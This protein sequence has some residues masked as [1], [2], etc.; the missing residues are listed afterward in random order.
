MNEAIIIFVVILAVV[1]AAGFFFKNDDVKVAP[2]MM[3]AALAGGLIAGLGLTIREVVEGPMAYVDSIMTVMTA[4]I[5]MML[6]ADNGTFDFLLSKVCGKKR[7]AM[8][9]TILLILFIAIP[10]IFT[11]TMTASLV[12][13]GLIAGKFMLKN[14]ID[15]TKT[16]EFVV[17]SAFI[18]MLLPPVNLPVMISMVSRIG[19]YP[20]SYFGVALPLL[21]LGGVALVL[22][23]LT[24]SNR[25]I[26]TT[27]FKAE[28]A[29]GSMTC[30]IPIAVAVL[31]VFANDFLAGIVPFIGYP[32]IFTIAAILAVILPARK[33]NPLESCVKGVGSVAGVLAVF[34]GMG[35]I[36]EI[37]TLTGVGGYISTTLMPMGAGAVVAAALVMILVMIVLGFFFGG[38]SATV[39]G[40]LF[41]YAIATLAYGK[42]DTMMLIASG[43]AMGIAF[44]VATRG[45]TVNRFALSLDGTTDVNFKQV[46][47]GG[48]LP[49][50]AVLVIS[51]V[52]V[53]MSKNLMFL[54]I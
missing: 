11:G 54:I 31:L 33:A 46:L 6:L 34:V 24:S 17:I 40:A 42:G 28:T 1:A 15:K 51:A 13:T 21:I 26:G 18:G 45:G 50:I 27:E 12:T 5:F 9:N 3:L 37:F 10:G 4:G 29:V 16:I 2:I 30:V 19:S 14:G 25:I 44:L 41:C 38:A 53:I 36:L 49:I 32:L 47:M 52:Y 22:Y 8:M 20:A 23:T 48:L 43:A 7:S 35:S 39:I